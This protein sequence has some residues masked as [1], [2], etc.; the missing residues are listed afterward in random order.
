VIHWILP[1]ADNGML[2]DFAQSESSETPGRGGNNPNLFC[3]QVLRLDSVSH[4]KKEISKD[5]HYA[6]AQANSRF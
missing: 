2:A 3:S 6:G 4:Y 5:D 1:F